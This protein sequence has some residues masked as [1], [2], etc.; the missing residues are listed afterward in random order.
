MKR[1]I[2]T[3]DNLKLNF[4]PSTEEE[5]ILQNLRTILSTVKY[6]VPLDR[7]FGVA[8]DFVDAP[9]PEARA[10]AENA[11]FNAIREYEPRVVVEKITWEE[12]V[13]GILRPKVQV[14]ISD[15]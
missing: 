4:N 9:T 10:L 7:S 8:A 12:T 1:L 13:D 5:E 11:Y 2:V 14:M 6:S 3:G 15:S